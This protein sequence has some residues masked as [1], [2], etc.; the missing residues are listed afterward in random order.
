MEQ[1]P[2]WAYNLGSWGNGVRRRQWQP[3]GRELVGAGQEKSQEA[4]TDDGKW[5]TSP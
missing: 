5:G 3:L 4:R 2:N 1:G